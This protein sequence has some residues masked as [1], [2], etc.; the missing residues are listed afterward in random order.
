MYRTYGRGTAS[1]PGQFRS[2]RQDQESRMLRLDG[3]GVGGP[4]ASGEARCAWVDPSGGT[5][6]PTR[7]QTQCRKSHA[8]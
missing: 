4:I 3:G 8:E 6:T 7:K 5:A 1:G 2:G